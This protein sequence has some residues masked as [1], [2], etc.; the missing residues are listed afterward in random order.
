MEKPL[1]LWF[2]VF[3]GCILYPSPWPVPEITVLVGVGW[4]LGPW[5]PQTMQQAVWTVRPGGAG[6]G[7]AS[8]DLCSAEHIINAH[9]STIS[10]LD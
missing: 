8:G 3:H 6:W 2:V 10:M 1:A 5:T 9:L 7:S 4:V